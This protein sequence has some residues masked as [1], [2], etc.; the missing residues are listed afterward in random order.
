[1]TPPTRSA[2]ILDD[3]IVFDKLIQILRFGCS[4]EVIADSI[5]SSAATND[6][7]S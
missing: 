2:S 7:K 5:A 4:Y 6:E 3:R 1:L